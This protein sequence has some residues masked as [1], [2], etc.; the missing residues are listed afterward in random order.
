MEKID[1]PAEVLEKKNRK[2][3]KTPLEEMLADAFGV[4]FRD[5]AKEVIQND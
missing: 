1:Y 5:K 2:T 3:R 4:R